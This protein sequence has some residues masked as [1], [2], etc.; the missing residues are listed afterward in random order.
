[1][2][3]HSSAP[4]QASAV[5]SMNPVNPTG[6]KAMWWMKSVKVYRVSRPMLPTLNRMKGPRAN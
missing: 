3:C 5:T 2:V 1:M 4:Y 6:R